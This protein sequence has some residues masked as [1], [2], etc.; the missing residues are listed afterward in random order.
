[1]AACPSAES[2]RRSGAELR[3][4]WESGSMSEFWKN[5]DG[6]EARGSRS[7]CSLLKTR[8]HEAPAEFAGRKIPP[9]SRGIPGDAL[10][11]RF[12]FAPPRSEKTSRL[13]RPAGDPR[14]AMPPVFH[15]HERLPGA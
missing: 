15:L 3:L 11:T 7:A 5:R 9:E 4:G 8:R 13:F 6:C 10:F 12:V 14:I 2:V 1:M